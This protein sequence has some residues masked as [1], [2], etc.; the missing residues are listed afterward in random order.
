[1]ANEISSSIVTLHTAYCPHCR[2]VTNLRES[3][4]LLTIADA[5][6]QAETVSMRTYHCEACHSFVR[7]EEDKPFSK[8]L[9]VFCSSK[10]VKECST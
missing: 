7:S 1:M 6:G 8:A 9:T 10:S 3:I 4:T 2:V 5:D